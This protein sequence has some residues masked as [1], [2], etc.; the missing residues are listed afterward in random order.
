MNTLL[1]VTLENI[2]RISMAAKT[3]PLS[4]PS[5]SFF[6]YS[7]LLRQQFRKIILKVHFRASWTFP[8]N[9]VNISQRLPPLNISQ[10]HLGGDTFELYLGCPFW[11]HQTSLCWSAAKNVRHSRGTVLPFAR[12]FLR[13][14][15]DIDPQWLEIRVF[16]PM[17]CISICLS[18]LSGLIPICMLK[19]YLPTEGRK[20]TH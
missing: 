19:A 14:K 20:L 12:I 1:C 6:P 10:P 4:A 16:S 18:Y 13:F 15:T 8:L 9:T 3:S 5:L 2:V 7:H 11:V 17:H